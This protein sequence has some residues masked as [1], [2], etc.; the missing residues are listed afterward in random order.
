[1][2]GG[3]CYGGFSLWLLGLVL[4]LNRFCLF[5]KNWKSQYFFQNPVSKP[6]LC[7]LWPVKNCIQSCM[8]KVKELRVLGFWTLKASAATVR[9]DAV[10]HISPHL[11]P[12]AGCEDWW[13]S[14]IMEKTRLPFL[15]SFLKVESK[16]PTTSQLTP[17]PED[18]SLV[19][20]VVV[21]QRGRTSGDCCRDLNAV[22]P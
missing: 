18:V 8:C 15:G 11:S 19:R 6:R 16:Q 21:K 3:W 10:P 9:S 13:I 5:K 7:C 12:C 2:A 22:P 1:M 14:K 17:L 20:H 4:V